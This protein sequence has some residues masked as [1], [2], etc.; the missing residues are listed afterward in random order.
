MNVDL[1]EPLEVRRAALDK[2]R[3]VHGSLRPDPSEPVVS[4][5]PAHLQWWLAG[6][7]G[8]VR[9]EILLS[10]ER[11][12]RVQSLEVTSVPDPPGALAALAERV[13]ALLSVPGPSWPDDLA[14]AEAIDRPTLDREL[15]A[16]EA[17]FGP[18]VLGPALSGDG[19]KTASWRLRGAR[20]DLT[21]T[22]ERDPADGT[23][24]AISLVPATLESPV[25]I[26]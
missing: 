12:P 3:A 8:R 4:W 7:R 10:P 5:S 6:D 19:V 11:P 25:E 14:L 26:G 1:D 9:V 22:V 17:L 24:R 23:V 13:A 20:G 2:L 16:A 15:R 21:L 18:V